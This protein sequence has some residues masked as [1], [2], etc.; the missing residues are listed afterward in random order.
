MLPSTL[1]P[2]YFSIEILDGI[3]C[4]R[5]IYNQMKISSCRNVMGIERGERERKKKKTCLGGEEGNWT[6]WSHNQCKYMTD[7]WWGLGSSFRFIPSDWMNE[8]E[9]RARQAIPHPR[10][11]WHLV[12][13]QA[14]WGMNVVEK[15]E[16][17]GWDGRREPWSIGEDEEDIRLTASWFYPSSESFF[18]FEKI[19]FIP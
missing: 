12:F 7:T 10:H 16:R 15:K 8:F 6:D 11:G 17:Y 1:F 14:H 2:F 13:H 19:H 4:N 9:C 18:S 5:I 3:G